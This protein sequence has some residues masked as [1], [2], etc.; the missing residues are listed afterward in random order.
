[1]TGP[2]TFLNSPAAAT[3]TAGD[4]KAIGK[5]DFL[6][7]LVTQLQ[8]QDPLSPL[9]PDQFAAQLAQFTSV[10]QLTKL[11]DAFALQN[12]QQVMGTM[13]SKTALGA[14]LIGRTIIA[15]GNQLVAT[16]A[17]TPSVRIDVGATGGQGTLVIKNL[18]GQTVSSTSLGVLSP[19]LQTIKPPALPSGNYT[20]EVQVQAKDGKPF[21][22]NTFTSGIVDGVTFEDGQIFLRMGSVKIPIDQLSEIAP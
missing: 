19:G 17:G 8:H 3:Q 9:Q 2:L 5:D 13:L 11:N 16:G 1:M 6:K 14:S 22:A 4:R 20:Y 18:G 7:L 15:Q 21:L 12:Q 10:E